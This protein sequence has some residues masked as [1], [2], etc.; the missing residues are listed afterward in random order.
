METNDR[1]NMTKSKLFDVGLPSIEVVAN[2]GIIIALVGTVKQRST[3]V[4]GILQDVKE[5]GLKVKKTTLSGWLKETAPSDIVIIRNFTPPSLK[6]KAYTHFME[7]LEESVKMTK[8]I[9]VLECSK[10][11]PQ[12]RHSRKVLVVDLNIGGD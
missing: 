2:K 1:K 11:V 12:I 4:K 5:D 6:A 7:V 8:E 10:L 3:A 9:I